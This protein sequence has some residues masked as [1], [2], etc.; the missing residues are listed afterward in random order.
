MLGFIRRWFEDRAA[1]KQQ[2]LELARTQAARAELI[3]HYR[4]FCENNQ[5]TCYFTRQSTT[6]RHYTWI[7]GP[8]KIQQRVF[9]D[10]DFTIIEMHYKNLE[11]LV[12]KYTYHGPKWQHLDRW[13]LE[14]QYTMEHITMLILSGESYKMGMMEQWLYETKAY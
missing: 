2:A 14:D 1:K 7:Q 5:A 3:A 12:L 6:V 4:N 9:D 10:S 11:K 13:H 8:F